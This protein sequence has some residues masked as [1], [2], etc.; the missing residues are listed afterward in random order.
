M[1]YCLVFFVFAKTDV[2]WFLPPQEAK[3]FHWPNLPRF[4]T[5]EQSS[6]D[7]KAPEVIYTV[8]TRQLTSE[9][10]A[11]LPPATKQAAK[12]AAPTSARQN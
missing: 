3:Q 5:W 7:G 10:L 6:P 9:E 8:P 1:A 11:Q 2:G 4:M 12:P